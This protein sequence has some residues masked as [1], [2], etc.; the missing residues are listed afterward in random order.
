MRWR[1]TQCG[2]RGV[3]RGL[4]VLGPPGWHGREHFARRWV[5]DIES[6]RVAVDPLAADEHLVGDASREAVSHVAVNSERVAARPRPK[7]ERATTFDGRQLRTMPRRP[8]PRLAT[9]SV[10]LPSGRAFVECVG[11][12]V[13]VNIE[14]LYFLS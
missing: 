1:A 2:R 6:A 13:I 12:L 3:N 14:C 7:S 10:F 4:H 11:L 5:E 9:C 8:P